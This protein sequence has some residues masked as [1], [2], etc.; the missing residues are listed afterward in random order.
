MPELPEVEAIVR[1]LRPQLI[2]RQIVGIHSDWPKYFQLP[3]TQ[4][5]AQDCITRRRITGVERRAKNILIHLSGRHLLVIHQKIS[6]R[7]LIGN[8][9][10]KPPGPLETDRHSL[11][12]AV[13]SSDPADPRR[14]RF[15]H[16]VFD[17]DDGRQLALSD[18][19]KFAKV[20]C[21]PEDVIAALPALRKLGPE[22]LDAQF[23]FRRFEQLFSRKK[24]AI[25]QILMDPNFIAGIG[26]LYSDE[27]LYA[28]KLHPLSRA[29]HLGRTHLS[30]LYRAMR[31]ML[32]RAIALGG[33]G[34]PGPGGVK[35]GYDRV[36]MVYGREGEPCPR[37]HIIERIKIGGRSAHFCRA[38]QELI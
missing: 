26:N 14:G 30:A 23:T 16:L 18:L 6:G 31:G 17:L 9:E 36:L 4:A 7:L 1:E 22:P 8:W 28:A 32:L 20:L 11:W 29:E 15:I 13:P 3:K 34:F 12:R 33:T 21:G 38:E 19:R 2:G 10:R 25:K 35:R 27:I 24:G 5:K 37:G